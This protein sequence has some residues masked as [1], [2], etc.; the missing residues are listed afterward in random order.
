MN[1]GVESKTIV[2]IEKLG[3]REESLRRRREG[4][5]RVKRELR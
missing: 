2:V 1:I 4:N 5:V 3:E